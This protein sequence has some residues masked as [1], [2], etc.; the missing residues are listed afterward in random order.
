MDAPADLDPT[1]TQEWVDSIKALAHHRGPERARF[2]LGRVVDAGNR[3]GAGFQ[4][5]TT[6]YVN[7]IAPDQQ[8]AFPGNREIEHKIRSAIRWN[9]GAPILR[10]S[11]KPSE[12]GAN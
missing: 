3:S 1:E 6:P 5:A 2:V 11:K 8:P 10:A 4:A 7:T 12:L 9:S